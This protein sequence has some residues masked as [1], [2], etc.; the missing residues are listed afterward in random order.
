EVRTGRCSAV[1]S[2]TDLA[3]YGVLSVRRGGADSN[4]KR[5][6]RGAVKPIIGAL[7]PTGGSREAQRTVRITFAFAL[8]AV[9]LLAPDSGH[10][11][12]AG[13][14]QPAN[15]AQPVVSPQRALL[16]QYCVGCHNQRQKA[17]GATPIALDTLDVGNVGADRESWEKVVLKLRGNLMPPAGR[18]RP[19]K[20]AHN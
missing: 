13:R 3:S 8:G 5:D 12:A 14:Q 16:N 18:P 17:A 15:A 4:R 9:V 20:P 7:L 6:G 19:D 11:Q 10:V 1:T 2:S